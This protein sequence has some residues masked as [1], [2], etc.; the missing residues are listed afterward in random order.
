MNDNQNEIP[1]EKEIVLAFFD[2]LGSSKRLMDNEYQKVY[3]FYQYMV[4]LCSETEVPLSH[5]GILHNLPEKEILIRHPMH[6]AFFSDT[7]ILWVEYNEFLQPRMG[8]FY[9]KCCTIFIESI[10]KGIPLRGSIARGTA[11]MDENNKLFLGK[12]LAE[13]AKAE[14]AQQWLGIGITKSCENIYPT[15]ARYL[16]PFTEHIKEGKEELLSIVVLDW[17]RY[18]RETEKDDPT[19][20]IDKMNTDD[21]FSVYYEIAKKYIQLS[22]EHCDFMKPLED[23]APPIVP[24]VVVRK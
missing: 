8:G 21:K 11:I 12:P 5:P 9:E 19:P 17:A 7:F 20:Y 2:I 14:P 24:M 13:A 1:E 4:K 6:H 15:E 22:K 10:K 18:F 16:F 23:I 3:E